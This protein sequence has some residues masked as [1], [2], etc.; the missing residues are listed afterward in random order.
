MSGPAKEELERFDR[1]GN[2]PHAW[3][4]TAVMLLAAADLLK[5]PP[6]REGMIHPPEM[7]LRGFALECLLKG[8]WVSQSKSLY[9]DGQYQR[10]KDVN[11][12]DV[13]DHDLR[14]LA[15]AIG[16]P[17]NPE[18]RYVLERLTA[19]TT[20]IGRYPLPKRP[21]QQQVFRWTSGD[22]DVL[23]AI[24]ADVRARLRIKLYERPTC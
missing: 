8:L 17:L 10:V 20:V 4:A 2:D 24:M 13:Q 18:Q 5:N 23:D 19:Y 21:E 12:H 7:M 11:G 16:F 3:N 1:V 22:S 9:K 14:G 6:E 15:D